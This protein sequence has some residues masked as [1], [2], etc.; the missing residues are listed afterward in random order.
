MEREDYLRVTE[1]IRPFTGIEF[2]PDDI[3]KPAGER[4][5]LVHDYIEK[6]LS[7]FDVPVEH[8][9]ALP[10]L[11][12]FDIFWETS[13][14]AFK[15]GKMIL[16]KRFYCDEWKIT[17][18][19]DCIIEVDN[20]VYIFDWKTSSQVQKSWRLQGSAYKHLCEVNGLRDVDD[21]LFV[22]LSRD[23]KKPSLHK[24]D[25]YEE[26]LDIFHKCLEL[27]RWHNMGKTRETNRWHNMGKTRGDNR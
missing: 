1:V 26:D 14:H 24:Y 20:R 6:K 22:K 12:S 2:V 27:Y 9:Q 18:K 17:G 13:N 10:F 16:E 3:L 25:S 19:M 5:T 11:E 21:I 15:D 23:G 4:G 8:P 7:G